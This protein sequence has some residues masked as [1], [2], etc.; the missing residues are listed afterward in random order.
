M[1]SQPPSPQP[2]ESV[3]GYAGCCLHEDSTGCE[4]GE[5]YRLGDYHSVQLSDSSSNGRFSMIRKIGYD[6][7]STVWPA[8]DSLLVNLF[9]ASHKPSTRGLK[10]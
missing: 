9:L 10:L 7:F 3:D 1:S 2:E 8:V 6:S 4:L 5:P